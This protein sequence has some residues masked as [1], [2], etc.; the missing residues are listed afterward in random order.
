MVNRSP[1]RCWRSTLWCSALQARSRTDE[2]NANPGRRGGSQEEG[3]REED[4][5]EPRWMSPCTGLGCSGFSPRS[6][7]H[8]PGPRPWC[9][10]WAVP[11]RVRILRSALPCSLCA[12]CVR[13]IACRCCSIPNRTLH[14][15]ACPG[16]STP[17]L[18]RPCSGQRQ[19][20]LHRT[21][22]A[23]LEPG[24]GCNNLFVD[25]P[26]RAAAR[27]GRDEWN[28]GTRQPQPTRARRPSSGPWT[29][30]WTLPGCRS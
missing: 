27:V 20:R 28:A 29:T 7:V 13:F 11:V 4:G 18:Q 2:A 12:L 1:Q 22:Q 16:P 9:V 8:G 23:R 19:A 24:F 14:P 6:K 17:G 15:G 25:C 30:P 10:S 5:K 21:L 3:K 26:L